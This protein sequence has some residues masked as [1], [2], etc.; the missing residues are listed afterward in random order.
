MH[1]NNRAGRALFN[2][3]QF[4]HLLAY[5]GGQPYNPS[6]SIIEANTSTSVSTGLV[7][8]GTP[9]L[10]PRLIPTGNL[11]GTGASTYYN[12]QAFTIPGIFPASNG[13]GIVNYLRGPGVWQNDM[14]LVKVFHIT[15]KKTLEFRANGYN[16]FNQVRR[17]ASPAT[18]A[19]NASVQFKANGT[20]FAQGFYVYNTPDQLAARAVAGGSNALT[21][22]NQYRTGA[23]APNLTNVEPMRILELGLKFRF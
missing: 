21:V 2:G 1:F 22:Y 14:N 8:L 10:S 11:S 23:G 7:I 15:E 13:T 3:W 17:A 12:P 6:F 16:V 4:A 5:F 9:D 18:S 19:V 20:T